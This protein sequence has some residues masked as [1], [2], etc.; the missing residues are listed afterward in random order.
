[1]SYVR[2]LK[3]RESGCGRTYPKEPRHICEHCFGKL[4]VDYDYDQ[5]ARAL[6]REIIGGRPANMWR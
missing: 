1:M 3:C 4:E 5:I 6:S 2:G